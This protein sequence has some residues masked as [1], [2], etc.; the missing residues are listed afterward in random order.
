VLQQK[1]LDLGEELAGTSIK[2]LWA[3]SMEVRRGRAGTGFTLIDVAG[4]FGYKI[5]SEEFNRLRTQAMIDPEMAKTVLTMMKQSTAPTKAQL[6]R[7]QDLSFAAGI[8]SIAQ[9][10]GG[11]EGREK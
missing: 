5:R 1:A 2:S 9:A 10:Q 11:H 6:L 3:K 4:R 7:L 8:N